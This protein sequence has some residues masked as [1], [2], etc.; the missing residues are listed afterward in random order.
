MNYVVLNFGFPPLVIKSRERSRY[1]AAIQ[2][3][4]AGDF[5]PMVEFLLGNL[6]WVFELCNKAAHSL[7]PLEADNE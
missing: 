7:V 5:Q 4:D 3:S 6:R 2:S 1:M